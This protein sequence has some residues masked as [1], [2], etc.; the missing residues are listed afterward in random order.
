[1]Y[2]CEAASE[3]IDRFINEE[4]NENAENGDD[5]LEE[6]Y[7]IDEYD[8]YMKEEIGDIDAAGNF[9]DDTEEVID[10]MIVDGEGM[11]GKEANNDRVEDTFSRSIEIKEVMASAAKCRLKR[12]SKD[13]AKFPVHKKKVLT[14]QRQVNNI[15]AALEARKYDPLI[16]PADKGNKLYVGY[17]GSEKKK[18]IEKIRWIEE[19][20]ST[21]GRQR[22]CDREAWN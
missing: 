12:K 13:T 19:N 5:N 2:S 9:Q 10:I 7:N 3:E 21:T 1:M 18:D 4:T 6:L 20:I 8:N 22:R 11:S 16:L 15:D 17:L 14:K